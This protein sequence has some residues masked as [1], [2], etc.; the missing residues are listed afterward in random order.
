RR[1]S[2]PVKIVR[3]P[4]STTR[5]GIGGAL[6]YV[7]TVTIDRIV[8]PAIITRIAEWRHQGERD[9][10]SDR[11]SVMARSSIAQ[12][13][14]PERIQDRPHGRARSPVL[15][16]KAAARVSTSARAAWSSV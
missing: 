16:A 3:P 9:A 5:A 7:L 15:N 8:K 13:C 11:L 4:S 14:Q 12:L 6:S 2:S 1:T 10:V